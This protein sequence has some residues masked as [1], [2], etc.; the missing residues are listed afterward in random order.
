MYLVQGPRAWVLEH[1]LPVHFSQARHQTATEELKAKY[2]RQVWPVHGQISMLHKLGG[3]QS[4]LV[5]LPEVQYTQIL[6][7]HCA[8][9]R[10]ILYRLPPMWKSVRCSWPAAKGTSL[11]RSREPDSYRGT[12]VR[13]ICMPN[14]SLYMYIGP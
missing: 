2:E 6:T 7:I 4:V 9:V 10:I 3:Q 1:V 11:Q 8:T 5:C 12:I 14:G 13:Y